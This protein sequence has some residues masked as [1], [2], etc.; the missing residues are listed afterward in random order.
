MTTDERLNL[1]TRNLTEVLT[2]EDLKHLL[3]TDTP[4]RHYIGFEVSGKLFRKTPYWA[5]LPAY[6]S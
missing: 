4:L 5:L 2:E 1:I 6:E 3:E